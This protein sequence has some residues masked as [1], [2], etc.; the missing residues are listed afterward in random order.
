MDVGTKSRRR[1]EHDAT[2]RPR[3]RTKSLDTTETQRTSCTLDPCSMMSL[4][5]QRR[6]IPRLSLPHSHKPA[7]TNRRNRPS[8]H[9]NSLLSITTLTIP[10]LVIALLFFPL[11]A[12]SQTFATSINN[13]QC[14][15]YCNILEQVSTTVPLC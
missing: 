1:R 3:K 5:P 12:Y 4:K 14:E 9:T 15:S 6:R 10:F 8:P 7:P 13:C 11:Q 2:M